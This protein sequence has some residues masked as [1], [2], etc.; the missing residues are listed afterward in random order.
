LDGYWVSHGSH[1]EYNYWSFL[2][3]YEWENTDS[4][5]NWVQSKAKSYKECERE[6]VYKKK[7]D[8]NTFE[9]VTATNRYVDVM[10]VTCKQYDYR[11]PYRYGVNANWYRDFSTK[12]LTN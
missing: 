10:S 7:D 4:N 11:Y 8:G 5:Q 6:A 9:N 3:D 1:Q 12:K 2:K